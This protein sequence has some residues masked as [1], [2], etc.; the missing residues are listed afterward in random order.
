[1]RRA[2]R[3]VT[4]FGEILAIIGRCDVLR[5]ALNGEGFPYLLPLNFGEKVTDGR[6]EF[7]FHGAR[8]GT[9]YALM[10]RDS[11]ASFEMDCAHRLVADEEKGQCTM[12]YESV[13]GQ[14]RVEEVHEEQ[15]EEGLRIL[16][17]HYG[18]ENFA[19]NRAALPATRVFKLVVER[20]T[21]KRRKCKTI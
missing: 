4:D 18:K 6:V 3:E 16:L 10:E 13:I 8:E 21:A 14:G 20:M 11:R 12:E 1:M 19:Y 5:L 9:K 7:Y 2:D 17:A 15:K